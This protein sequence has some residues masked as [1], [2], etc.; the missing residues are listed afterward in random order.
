MTTVEKS[1][2]AKKTT[3]LRRLARK[4]MALTTQ[5]A[6]AHAE[7]LDALG[8]N[9]K[10]VVPGQGAYQKVPKGWRPDKAFALWLEQKGI[11]KDVTEMRPVVSMR[12]VNELAKRRPSLLSYV[13]LARAAAAQDFSLRFVAEEDD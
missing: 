11:M 8:P 6:A 10:I 1:K 2:E 9:E 7:L 5:L 13:T 3:E 4:V 12:K